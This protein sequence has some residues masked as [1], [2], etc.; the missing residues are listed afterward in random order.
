MLEYNRFVKKKINKLARKILL[1]IPALC[2]IFLMS[3]TALAKSTYLINDGG[4]ILLHST[5]ATDP[6]TILNEVG[7]PLG[8]E[9]TYTT[10][11]GSDFLEIRVQ[12]KQLVTVLHNGRTIYVTTYGES[13]G[14][15]LSRLNL[16]L[17]ADDVLS[18]PHDTDTYDGM[19]LTISKTNKMEE[20]YTVAIPYETVYCY[21]ASLPEGEEVILTAGVDGQLLCTAIV[22]Y[23]D[24]KEVS[25]TVL[26]EDVIRQPVNAV[27]AIGTYV[28]KPEQVPM[29][30]E[31]KPTQPKP[32][33]PAATQPKPTEPAPTQP[34]PT[35]PNVPSLPQGLGMPTEGDGFITTSTGEVL[36]IKGKMTVKAT[37]YSCDGKPGITYSGTPARVGAVAV[38]PSV[39]PLGTKMYV[40]SNDGA[41]IYGTCTAEDTG[42]A[43]KGKMLDLYFN[44]TDECWIFG[45]RNCTV[46]FLE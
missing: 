19:V 40:V 31:P 46:Y 22:N 25:R 43:I 28:D 30:T 35:Q 34:K 16:I 15:L 24:G 3:Q 32:T 37:A 1:I 41:Y 9:D 23:V 18:V 20:T 6:A 7:L 14:S 12:R 13:V 38:D 5:Y 8:E 11:E 44:T 45:I 21:D 10:Q 27:V 33:Q 36:K 42:G 26:S 39:I 29:P 4:R 2:I 17:E